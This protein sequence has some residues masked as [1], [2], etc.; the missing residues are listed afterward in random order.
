MALAKRK[1]FK[2]LIKGGWGRGGGGAVEGPSGRGRWRGGRDVRSA[3][4]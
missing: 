3:W 4:G 2:A 1:R